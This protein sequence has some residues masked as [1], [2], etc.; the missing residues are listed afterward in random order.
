MRKSRLAVPVAHQA[1]IGLS[2]TILGTV[3][4]DGSLTYRV[5]RLN[6]DAGDIDFQDTL[7]SVGLSIT[8]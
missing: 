4:L 1:S 7:A 5:G 3:I 8:F 6:P 2:Y